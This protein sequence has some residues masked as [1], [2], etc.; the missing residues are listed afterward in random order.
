MAAV[1]NLRLMFAKAGR[2]MGYACQLGKTLPRGSMMIAFVG[3]DG[4]GKTT[5]TRDIEKWLRY[6]LDAHAFYM[7]SGDGG[8]GSFDILCRST[9][10]LLGSAGIQKK[11]KRDYR[12]K[13]KAIG[14]FSKLVQLPQLVV[15]R[16]K[17]RLLRLARRM[18]QKGS[19]IITDRYPQSQFYGISDGP[20]LQN[21]RSFLWAARAELKLYEEAS[22]LGPDLLL[23]LSIDPQTAHRRNWITIYPS[24]NENVRSLRS[25]L[26]RNR[27][28]LKSMPGSHIAKCCWPPSGPFGLH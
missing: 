18:L 8:V 3:S 9:K 12:D 11:G 15:M 6:K 27:W 19:V 1:Q 10:G 20:K 24:L 22:R 21:G 28:P 13:T 7:G 5:L 25:S 23:K 14:F 4:S 2:R 16:H 26:S 17:L